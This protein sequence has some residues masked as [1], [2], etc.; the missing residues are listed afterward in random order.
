MDILKL[1]FHLV[2]LGTGLSNALSIPTLSMF[3]AT[4][5]QVKSWEIG[6]F[7]S[8]NALSSITISLLL[9]YCS[10]RINYRKPLLIFC[11]AMLMFNAF[12]FIFCR[13]YILL[14]TLGSLLSAC[15]SA[16]IPQLFALAKLTYCDAQF[17]AI[18]RAQFSF[19]WVVGPPLAYWL[20]KQSGFSTLY[21][22]ITAVI[23]IVLL[24]ST[25]LPSSL[26]L[27]SNTVELPGY[28]QPPH[29]LCYLMM[30]TLLIWTC[31]ALDLIAF[32]LH[33]DSQPSL[34]SD[35]VGVLYAVAAG[36]EIPAML[37]SA[38]LLRFF[39]KKCQMQIAMLCGIIFYAGVLL[40][41][42]FYS[43]LVLQIFNA[44]FIAVSATIGLFWFQDLLKNSQGVAA[45]LYT[46][47]VSV[48]ILIAGVMQ[49]LFT[50]ITPL[51]IWPVACALLTLSFI[52]ISKTNDV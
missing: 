49:S 27:P 9:A 37:L 41:Q 28:T 38:K 5:L 31:S 11:I 32:P 23:F 3:L 35:W 30:S 4:E 19:A 33:L 6:T 12:L 34:T 39:G 7:Y 40:S 44:F 21:T 48:G 16:T 42:N 52:F 15:G 46:N 1:R 2:A 25:R 18:L 24:L 47:A 26:S 51:A 50:H 36:L 14:I 8:I 20:I 17:S 22:V 13:N 10:D 45:T 29:N 43:L